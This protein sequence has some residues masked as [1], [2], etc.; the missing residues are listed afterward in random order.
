ML[1]QSWRWGW[2]DSR[3]ARALLA[4]L[5][6]FATPYYVG[7]ATT[8]MIAA[9]LALALHLLVGATG[10]VS[11]GHGAFYGLAAYVVFWLSPRRRGLADLADAARRDAGRRRR[12]A[13]GRRAVAAHARLL[14]PDGDAR[15]RPDDLLRLPRHQARRQQ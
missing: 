5:P 1:P 9:M 2:L 11:L 6:F 4:A 15:L 7:L 13:R 14:L 10:L 12:G 3:P 8:A